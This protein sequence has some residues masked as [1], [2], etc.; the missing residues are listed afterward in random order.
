MRKLQLAGSTAI[1]IVIGAVVFNA[2]TAEAQ[3]AVID[4]DA[5]ARRSRIG[6]LPRD[7]GRR[8]DDERHDQHHQ[9]AG[10]SYR[11]HS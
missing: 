3:I 11:R 1:G 9:D 7:Q 6:D 8:H 5:I 4:V 2:I 10:Q